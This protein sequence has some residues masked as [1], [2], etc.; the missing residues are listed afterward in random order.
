MAELRQRQPV[1]RRRRKMTRAQREAESVAREKFKAEVLALD[2]YRCI[3][4][5]VF[6]SQHRCTGPLQAHHIPKQQWLRTHISSLELTE[7]EILEWLWDAHL[8]ATV[9]EGLHA[10]HTTRLHVIPFEWLPA[11]VIDRATDREI[12]H[13]VER[14][15]PPLFSEV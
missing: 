1:V 7:Q 5:T 4:S 6:A 10:G 12:L 3:G 8:G 15:H 9:C 11:R 2:R 13:L 14:E